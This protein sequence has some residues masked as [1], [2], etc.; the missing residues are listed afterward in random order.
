[1]QSCTTK[2]LSAERAGNNILSQRFELQTRLQTTK[3][4]ER[5]ITAQTLH[6]MFCEF[7][8]ELCLLFWHPILS[9]IL[10]VNKVFE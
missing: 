1:M 6:E 4:K 9:H 8:N 7:R 5:C 3:A 10:E 2:W